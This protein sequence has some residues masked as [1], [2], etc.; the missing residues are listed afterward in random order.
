MV[1]AGRRAAAMAIP[2]GDSPDRLQSVAVMDSLVGVVTG[3]GVHWLSLKDGK[4]LVAKVPGNDPAIFVIPR[5]P[6]WYGVVVS[7]DSKRVA[8]W[9]L[10]KQ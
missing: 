9:L 8:V 7:T 10:R 4:A 2:L 5:K 3:T 1:L 6:G